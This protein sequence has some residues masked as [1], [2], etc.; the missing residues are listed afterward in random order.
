MNA[1]AHAPKIT[2]KKAI[3]IYHRYQLSELIIISAFTK[4]AGRGDKA[5]IN[6]GVLQMLKVERL[7]NF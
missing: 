3:W 6:L 7:D 4:R 2:E 5:L 1:A